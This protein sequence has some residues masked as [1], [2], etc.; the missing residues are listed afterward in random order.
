MSKQNFVWT[1]FL[2]EKHFCL[3]NIIGQKK[4]FWSKNVWLKRKNLGKKNSVQKRFGSQIDFGS[5]KNVVSEKILGPEKF[6]VWKNLSKNKIVWSEKILEMWKMLGMG[7]DT[8]EIKLVR[9]K[10]VLK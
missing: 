2:S 8:I 5:E 1:K 4:K 7:F 10:V 6:L 3:K 9:L